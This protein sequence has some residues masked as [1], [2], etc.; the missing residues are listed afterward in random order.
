MIIK[1]VSR[2]I[3]KTIDLFTRKQWKIEKHITMTVPIEKKLQELMK[4]KKKLQ[5]IYPTDYNL[6]LAQ[7]LW[8]S[9]YQICQ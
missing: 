2:R 6:L 7:D 1:D 8:Q 4:M 3:W 5:K 9:H